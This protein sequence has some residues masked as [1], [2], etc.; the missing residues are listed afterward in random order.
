LRRVLLVTGEYPPDEG[1]VADYTRCLAAALAD[2]GHTVDV[3]TGRGRLEDAPARR[4]TVHRVLRRW[5][6][7]LLP[8]MRRVVATLQPDVVHVQYQTA[9]FDMQPA[10]NTLAWWLRK[11]T[12]VK[13][14]VTY[15]DVKVPYLFPK[16]GSLRET[17]TFLPARWSHLTIATNAEDW[18]T[19]RSHGRTWRL[20]LVPIGSNVPDA[21]PAGYD[22]DAWR[23]EQ[24]LSPASA[25]LAYFGFLN[26]S[27]GGRVLVDLLGQLRA[28]GQD[29]RLVMI[30]GRTGASDPN[31]AAYLAEFEADVAS[32]GLTG[33]VLWTGHVSPTEVSAWLRAADVAV[34]P[35]TDGASYRRG[36]LLACL[37][38]GLPIVTTRP[39][40]LALSDLSTLAADELPP[41]LTDSVQALLVPPGD[42]RAMADAVARILANPDTAQQ[43]GT[44][45]RA[46]SEWFGWP[47]IAERHAALYD[48]L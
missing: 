44:A 6:W 20:A 23:R 43:L 41:D 19:L 26:A 13:T 11:T 35:Y 34:L 25:L 24:G 39:P 5:G 17:V 15:H 1:G 29:A 38:H 21:P 47:K 40:S 37:A 8:S 42:A 7:G 46:L 2:L 33:A 27:K 30:G 10:V 22:R 48:E 4:V 32:A 31:N 36:S 12:S 3:L 9:A 16:A 18:A 45:A 28:A 14:A